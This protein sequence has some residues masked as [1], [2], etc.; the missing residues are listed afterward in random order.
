M[1][2]LTRDHLLIA[3]DIIDGIGNSNPILAELER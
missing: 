2:Y 1:I 3:P